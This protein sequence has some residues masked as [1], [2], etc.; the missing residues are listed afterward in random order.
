MED[1]SFLL[2]IR[3][4]P[5]KGTK[6]LLEFGENVEGLLKI[7]A[8]DLVERLD[9]S[10]LEQVNQTFIPDNL[11]KQE[12]DVLYL[13]PFHS[14]ELGEVWIYVL[15][16]HQST[17]SD[18]MGFRILFYM[19]QIWD[20][21]RRKWE[22]NKI[23]QTQWRFRPILP[24]VL[25]TGSERW[26]APIKLEALMDVPEELRRFV[27]SFDTLF[28][29]VKGEEERDFLQMEHPLSW[30]LAA[31]R[32]ENADKATFAY[33]LRRAVERLSQLPEEEIHQWTRAMYYLVLLIYH[34]RPPTEHVE[35]RE[36]V[37]QNIKDRRRRKEMEEMG[38]TIAD[39]LI[40]EGKEIGEKQGQER[41]ELKAKREDLLKLIQLRFNSVP[42]SVVKKVRSIRRI[43][44]LD[45]LFEKAAIA[46][47]LSEIETV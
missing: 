10:R 42:Q 17:P 36:I 16:E 29:N 18:V 45:A 40:Q 22:D 5:D 37:E 28:L 19:T 43:D 7:V 1:L 8:N 21:Q 32:Q 41:G 13:V 30:L 9:F 20:A 25:Y 15:I 34:R 3:E 6:W 39:T 38:Q 35:L 44:R 31:I 47:S 23:P 46:K 12:S 14:E 33:M 4:F 24:I 11:R 27:P 26:E 2:P